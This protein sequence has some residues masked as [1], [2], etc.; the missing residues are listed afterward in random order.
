VAYIVFLRSLLRLLVTANVVPSLPILDNLM[1][2]VVGSSE[3]LVTT[4]ATQR[5][6]PEDGIVHSRCCE[7]LKYN[8]PTQSSLLISENKFHTHKEPQA[9]L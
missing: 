4:K 5:I 3:M 1:M 9:K 7:N 8:T 6:I 2:Q